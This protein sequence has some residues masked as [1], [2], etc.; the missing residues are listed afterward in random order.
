MGLPSPVAG[1]FA[2][3]SSQPP[4]R[5]GEG[6]KDLLLPLSASGRGLGGGVSSPILVFVLEVEV[7]VRFLIEIRR[8]TDQL[9]TPRRD[10]VMEPVLA[11][12]VRQDVDDLAAALG[13]VI[14]AGNEEWFAVLAELELLLALGGIDVA[15]DQF[16]LVVIGVRRKAQVPGVGDSVFDDL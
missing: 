11:T 4:P 10:E 7:T 8:Q 6:E 9:A 13:T 12:A 5:D 3:P 1:C 2:H 14:G 16:R 15:K